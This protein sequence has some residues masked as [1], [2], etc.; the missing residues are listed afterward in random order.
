M[1]IKIGAV[2]RAFVNKDGD[3]SVCNL[4]FKIKL[5]D[6]TSMAPDLYYERWRVYSPFDIRVWLDP[7][8]AVC[9][10]LGMGFVVP[11]GFVLYMFLNNEHAANLEMDELFITPGDCDDV[12]ITIRCKK[13]FYLRKYMHIAC[14]T[15][16][17]VLNTTGRE[18]MYAGNQHHEYR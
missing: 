4:A 9:F 6:M 15:I 10:Y 8:S 16:L 7:G 18:V 2:K 11:K 13:S 14:F 12:M 1:E 5:F 3:V 17:P